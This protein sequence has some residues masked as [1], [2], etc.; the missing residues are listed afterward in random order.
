[1]LSFTPW[2]V[3]WQ[4]YRPYRQRLS[5]AVARGRTMPAHACFAACRLMSVVQIVSPACIC[6]CTWGAVQGLVLQGGQSR[7]PVGQVR[8]KEAAW[9]APGQ[10]HC[11]PYILAKRGRSRCRSG[12]TWQQGQPAGRPPCSY[13]A[14]PHAAAPPHAPAPDTPPPPPFAFPAPPAPPDPRP[15]RSLN[16][17]PPP[18][19]S[20]LQQQSPQPEVSASSG[21]G[22]SKEGV[23][24]LAVLLPTLAI[25]GVTAL[26]AVVL[27][28]RRRLGTG[29]MAAP[30][31]GPDTTL[32]VTDIQVRVATACMARGHA[33]MSLFLPPP[34]PR[35]ALHAHANANASTSC[36]IGPMVLVALPTGCTVSIAHTPGRGLH[37]GTSTKRCCRTFAAGAAPNRTCARA[38]GLTARSALHPHTP[39]QH[40][41]PPTHPMPPTPRPRCRTR[42]PCGRPCRQ[43]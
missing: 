15:R 29:R 28:R 34:L 10:G 4:L 36:F 38:G 26:L 35:P 24:V 2:C 18:P 16:Y 1:M 20:P 21:G 42:L 5:T 31:P 22:L 8:M 9:R 3:W 32:L 13:K 17:V 12:S 41:A 30:G 6:T 43:T 11:M 23:V 27:L 33:C 14:S 37:L 7:V 25:C 40:S 19:P 39:A